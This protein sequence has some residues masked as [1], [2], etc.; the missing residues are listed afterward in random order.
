MNVGTKSLLYGAHCFFLHPLFVAMSWIKLYSFPWDLRIW[1]CFICHDWGYF[2]STSMDGEDGKLHP[3]LG[4]RIMGVFGRDWYNFSLYHSRSLA[5]RDNV[6]YSKLC[7]PDKYAM[8]V[9]PKWLYLLMVQATGEIN[10]YIEN[11]KSAPREIFN[12]YELSRLDENTAPGWYDAVSNYLKRWALLHKNHYTDS[13]DHG[14][15]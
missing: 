2:G 12:E 15:E 14:Y 13:W 7:V 9:T 6:N 4:A 10:E 3:Y 5:K 1:L 8:C 11:A